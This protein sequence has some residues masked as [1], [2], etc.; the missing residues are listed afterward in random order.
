[1]ASLQKSKKEKF[2]FGTQKTF[3]NSSQRVPKVQKT[4]IFNKPV[5]HQPPKP[6]GTF[7]IIHPVTPFLLPQEGSAPS[8][9]R[10][11]WV[12]D[13]I[14]RYDRH[15]EPRFRKVKWGLMARSPFRFFRGSDELF[16]SDLAESSL[17]ED[18]GGGKGT[19]LWLSGD[20]HCEN[21]GSFSDATGRLVFELNDFDEAVIADYQMDLWRLCVSLVLKS[22]ET[23]KNPKSQYR[24]ALEAAWGYWQ[25]LKSCRWYENVRH[26]PWDEE[27]A[28]GSVRHFLTHVRKNAGYQPMLDRW[29][30]A[31]KKGVTFLMPG[32]KDLELIPKPIHKKLEKALHRYTEDLRPWPAGKPR[33]FEVLDLARRLNGGI[34]SEGLPRY[35]A[36]VRVS[37][38]GDR[39]FR[40]LEI[41]QVV[42]P[43]PWGYMPKK[44]RRKTQELCGE[45]QGLRV[46]LAMEAL[47]RH[48][49]PWLGVLTLQG[50]DFVVRER[51][52]FKGQLPSELVDESA[53]RQM[54]GIL[55]RAHCRAR[56]SFAKKAFDLIR[57]D[58]KTFRKRSAEIAMAYADQVEADHK[59][60]KT[61]KAE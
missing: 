14:R 33:L 21:F 34:G 43:S 6:Q 22:R 8:P 40:I 58:K 39:P 37:E 11:A 10:P 16:W 29:T 57:G 36:L 3:G 7:Y 27:Q 41:K 60:F 47:S 49:D 45:D 52:P 51:S 20:A 61:L 13:Q 15:L 38:E 2:G 26:S 48:P 56:G 35:Y 23:Q 17:L 4:S 55:A 30:K 24:M 44:A 18:F 53:A 42:E 50:E 59:A 46:T 28:E 54:G 5:S 32:N 31:E 25:E 12:R 9:D 19:R 1:M